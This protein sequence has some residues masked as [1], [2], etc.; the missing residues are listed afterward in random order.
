MAVSDLTRARLHELLH[1][2]PETGIFTWKMNRGAV[3]VGSEA[4]TIMKFKNCSYRYIMID[5]KYHRAH[6][7]AWFYVHGSWP[8][9]HLDHINNIGTDNRIVNLREATT[10]ENSQAPNRTMDP[11][12]TS[13]FPGV[14]RKA[15]RSKWNA[16]IQ[17]NS[18]RL[19]LGTFETAEEASTAY[20]VA[21]RRL[22]AFCS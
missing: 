8:K 20:Q 21:K 18:K 17:V 16:S 6:R 10:A 14:S 11:R 7:L 15:G 5:F 4:G 13:G 1:Y 12:N 3:A 2:S 9:N 19:Y 22:H